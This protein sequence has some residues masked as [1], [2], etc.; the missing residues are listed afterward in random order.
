[1]LFLLGVD[2]DNEARRAVHFY[3]YLCTEDGH[4][5]LSRLEEDRI[6]IPLCYAYAAALST[7]DHTILLLSAHH[8]F[9]GLCSMSK[10]FPKAN[11]FDNGHKNEVLKLTDTF[12]PKYVEVMT[13]VQNEDS[14][15]SDGQQLGL[16]ERIEEYLALKR[17]E[18]RAQ[19]REPAAPGQAQLE[20]P[21]SGAPLS[22][23]LLKEAYDFAKNGLI[24]ERS[25]LRQYN[26]PKHEK[27]LVILH[28]AESMGAIY[29]RPPDHPW[30]RYTEIAHAMD[31]KN[32][33]PPYDMALCAMDVDELMKGNRFY[34]GERTLVQSLKD[35]LIHPGSQVGVVLEDIERIDMPLVIGQ[36]GRNEETTEGRWHLG[37]DLRN[38][39]NTKIPK[40]NDDDEEG[41]GKGKGKGKAEDGGGGGRR[42][43]QSGFPVSPIT[44][45]RV[46]FLWTLSCCTRDRVVAWNSSSRVSHEAEVDKGIRAPLGMI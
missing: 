14:Q 29:K 21:T 39:A 44:L 17:K 36:D 40:N 24:R 38:Y 23:E 31:R 5:E 7:I 15:A 8:Q 26:L 46:D 20:E 11:I 37:K 6:L 28:N 34:K 25:T 2:F 42:R 41:K 16:R 45:K 22:V 13:K 33:A 1:M 4:G 27:A 9:L 3:Y 35:V 43:T 30:K 10:E 18:G 32:M 19:T 12:P